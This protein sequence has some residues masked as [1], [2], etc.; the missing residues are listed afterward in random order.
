MGQKGWNIHIT[1]ITISHL[2]LK[3][4]PTRVL[5]QFLRDMCDMSLSHV[6]MWVMDEEL[7]LVL[8]ETL[9]RIEQK[10][11][12]LIYD[13]GVDEDDLPPSGPYGR[14]RDNGEVL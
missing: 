8:L 11:D 1:H 4:R 2:I 9:Q 14:E 10:L 13:V 7:M 3:S 5:R 12:A 6:I